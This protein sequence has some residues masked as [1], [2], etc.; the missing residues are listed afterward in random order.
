M[1]DP[2]VTSRIGVAMGVNPG[3]GELLRSIRAAAAHAGCDVT[4][5]DRGDTAGERSLRTDFVDGMLLVPS[6]GDDAV[7]NGLVR[8]GVP[9]VLVDR[10]VARNDV[11]QVGTENVHSMA[12]GEAPDLAAAPQDRPDFGRRRPGHQP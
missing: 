6:P 4:L 9:T 10:T 1:W 5:V 12:S 8:M 3:S 2:P 7:I 11:D